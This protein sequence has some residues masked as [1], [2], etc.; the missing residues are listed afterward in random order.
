[1]AHPHMLEQDRAG[2]RNLPRDRKPQ[3][4]GER[5]RLAAQ[6]TAHTVATET[7]DA[8]HGLFVC[9]FVCLFAAG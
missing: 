8:Q 4:R 1:V 9:L 2:N 6:L 7:P 5:R 3:Y